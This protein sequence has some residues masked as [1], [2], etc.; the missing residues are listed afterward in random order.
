M[1][2]TCKNFDSIGS[3]SIDINPKSGF[4]IIRQFCLRKKE[5]NDV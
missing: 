5:E 4:L 3:L 1:I 2:S